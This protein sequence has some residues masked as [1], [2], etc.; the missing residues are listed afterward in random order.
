MFPLSRA[1]ALTAILL[2]LAGC[3]FDLGTLKEFSADIS[4]WDTKLSSD[5]ARWRTIPVEGWPAMTCVGPEAEVSDCCQLPASRPQVDCQK[6]ASECDQE[7][8]QCVLYFAYQESATIDLLKEAPAL[9]SQKSQVPQKVLLKSVTS[10]FS[11]DFEWPLPAVGMYV[12]PAATKDITDPQAVYL[13]TIPP[14]NA[15]VP[16]DDSAQ[17]AFS[18]FAVNFTTPFKLFFA[19]TIRMVS[20]PAPQGHLAIQVSGRI[21]ASFRKD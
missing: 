9:A 12:A 14:Q 17:Q 7:L 10:S 13:A 2:L 21:E 3:K 19:S 11:S 5:D 18:N 16:L 4:L 8:N 6:A 1:H 20:G 15:T